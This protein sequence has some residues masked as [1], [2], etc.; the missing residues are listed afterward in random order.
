MRWSFTFCAL[1]IAA[2]ACTPA[3]QQESAGAIGRIAAA[4]YFEEFDELCRNDGGGLCGVSLCGPML[5]VD[6]AT[7][8]VVGDRAD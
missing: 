6:P 3:P 5:L 1:L 2:L 7:R 8:V 4:T